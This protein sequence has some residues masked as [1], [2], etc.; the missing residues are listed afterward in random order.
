MICS[1]VGAEGP[2]SL[3]STLGLRVPKTPVFWSVCP[4][5]PFQIH[6]VPRP[7]ILS[8]L[9]QL[10]SL[11]IPFHVALAVILLPESRAHGCH[12]QKTLFPGPVMCAHNGVRTRAVPACGVRSCVVGDGGSRG[13]CMGAGGRC[14]SLCMGGFCWSGPNHSRSRVSGW[15]TGGLVGGWSTQCLPAA[16]GQVCVDYWAGAA[17]GGSFRAVA[18][19]AV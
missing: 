18:P 16:R 8:P 5:N 4:R 3:G 9:G 10:L 12:M 13:N 14:M 17:S 19:G 1:F 7:D 6:V 15:C 2:F 11:L